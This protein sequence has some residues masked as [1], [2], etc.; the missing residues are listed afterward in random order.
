MLPHQYY[1]PYLVPVWDLISAIGRPC[2]DAVLRKSRLA[3]NPGAGKSS[4]AAFSIPPFEPFQ[5][6]INKKE[7]PFGCSFLLV[8]V[9]GLDFGHRQ[10]L[11]GRC[12]AQVAPGT[13]SRGGKKQHCCLFHSALRV[14]SNV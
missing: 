7:H 3:R 1:R 14:P 5:Y 9:V 11:L 6:M 10:A 12:P 13:K 4:T 2:L 8:P